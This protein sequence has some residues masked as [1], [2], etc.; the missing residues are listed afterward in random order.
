MKFAKYTFLIA[1]I[2]GL[3]VLL[4]QYFFEQRIGTNSPPSITHPEFFYGF[5]GV[6]VAFQIVFLIISRDPRKYRLMIIPSIVEKFSFGIAV[7][8]LFAFGRVAGQ[9]FAA[10]ML[11]T[12]LGILFVVS[13]FKLDDADEVS[14]E[15]ESIN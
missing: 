14:T 11:D 12:L 10:A 3:L 15:S 2:Y 13:W 8:F 1:G 9:M 7:T 5:I 6:G 4:P